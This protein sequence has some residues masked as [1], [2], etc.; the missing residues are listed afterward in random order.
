MQHP[1]SDTAIKTP[2]HRS[3]EEIILPSPANETAEHA[4]RTDKHETVMRDMQEEDTNMCDVNSE[5]LVISEEPY[6]SHIES[7][8]NCQMEGGQ[9]SAA[10]LNSET[11]V[12][13]G[14][15]SYFNLLKQPRVLHAYV[16]LFLGV[17]AAFGKKLFTLF[18]ELCRN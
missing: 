9:R 1:R 6:T 2:S 15:A 18:I 8:S 3:N 5:C 13:P 17:S 16:I 12:N 14:K 4:E 10:C 11:E 7:T